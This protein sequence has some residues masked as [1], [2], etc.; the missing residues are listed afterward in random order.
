MAN[1]TRREMLRTGFATSASV[2]F[3]SPILARVEDEVSKGSSNPT[4]AANIAPRE[5]LLFDCDWKF[6]L[7]HANDAARDLGFGKS[8]DAFSKSGTFDFANREFDDSKWRN[9]DL[10]HDWAIEL[11][12]VHDDSLQG[13]GYKPLGKNYPETSVGWYR[14]VFEVPQEDHGRRIRVEFDGA[15]RSALVFL[16]SHGLP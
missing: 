7:G 3:K 9:L 10:P 14:R 8:Q 4:T 1:W 13:H 15:F 16:N 5:R 6:L 12:F 2:L 11:P